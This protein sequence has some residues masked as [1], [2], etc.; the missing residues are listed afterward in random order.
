[1]GS[2]TMLSKSQWSL[3]VVARE[4][5]QR[6]LLYLFHATLNDVLLSSFLG[7]T[8]WAEV[9]AIR[10]LS[11]NTAGLVVIVEVSRNVR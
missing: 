2:I 6:S 7:G 5:Y 10:V 11:I 3:R 1:M 4:R 9:E 8:W